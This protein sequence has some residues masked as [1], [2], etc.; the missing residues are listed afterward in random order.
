[1]GV[2]QAILFNL[3]YISVALN[4]WNCATVSVYKLP[5]LKMCLNDRVPGPIQ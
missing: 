5:N 1:M 4:E 3:Y 2:A